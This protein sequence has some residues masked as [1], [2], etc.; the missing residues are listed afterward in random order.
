MWL[1]IVDF[2]VFFLFLVQLVISLL[3]LN[4]IFLLSNFVSSETVFTNLYFF[5]ICP[6]ITFL[7]DPACSLFSLGACLNSEAMK[8]STSNFR[9]ILGYWLGDRPLARSPDQPRRVGKVKKIQTDRLTHQM[10]L[11]LLFPVFSSSQLSLQCSGFSEQG[12]VF[13]LEPLDF[14]ISPSQ[15]SA[16]FV[17]CLT[18]LY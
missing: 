3:A 18:F 7:K 6:A 10:M 14:L 8:F 13:L 5:T 1:D 16:N 11:E 15:S 9:R 17:S 12:L 2:N 4:V